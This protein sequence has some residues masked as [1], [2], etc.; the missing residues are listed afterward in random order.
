MADDAPEFTAA[1]LQA[2]IDAT[3]VQVAAKDYLSL[4]AFA[5]LA[6]SG[7]TTTDQ[8]DVG[9]QTLI[10]ALGDPDRKAAAQGLKEQWDGLRAELATLISMANAAQQAA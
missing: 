9:L 8:L 2:Q 10:D 7:T 3:K 5:A 6:N 4:I 1:E